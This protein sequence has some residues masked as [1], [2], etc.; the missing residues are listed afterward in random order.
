MVVC[1]PSLL[2]LG[3]TVVRR[4]LHNPD[5]RPLSTLAGKTWNYYSWNCKILFLRRTKQSF[6]H[7]DH[8]FDTDSDSAPTV[9]RSLAAVSASVPRALRMSECRRLDDQT[10]YRPTTTT[11]VCS[12][13]E[14]TKVRV[15]ALKLPFSFQRRI[16]RSVTSRCVFLSV[17]PYYLDRNR[18]SEK[19][20]C[21]S[22]TSI[23]F[24][25]VRDNQRPGYHGRVIWND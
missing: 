4:L 17:C 23:H 5:D 2:S 7:P 19:W 10:C 6:N 18:K 16:L 25:S 11:P 8:W 3:H 21:V 13:G 14:R 24:L 1:D 9:W 20:N 22:K 15:T 12:S